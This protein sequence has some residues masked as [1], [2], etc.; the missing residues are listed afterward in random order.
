MMAASDAG[1]AQRLSLQKRMGT[2]RAARGAGA[3]FAASRQRN[4]RSEPWDGSTA[5]GQ[6][7]TDQPV[8]TRCESQREQR[9]PKQREGITDNP[10]LPEARGCMPARRLGDHMRMLPYG[11]PKS[12]G[13]CHIRARTRVRKRAWA[14]TQGTCTGAVTWIGA[15]T[16]A[17]RTSLIRKDSQSGRRGYLHDARRRRFRSRLAL[18][19]VSRSQRRLSRRRWPGQ[20]HTSSIKQYVALTVC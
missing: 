10:R 7:S 13:S 16:S 6:G 20:A 1:L 9:K 8:G 2:S 17:A 4:C 18:R 3:E 14:V 19:M 5:Q 12:P 11:R 15:G